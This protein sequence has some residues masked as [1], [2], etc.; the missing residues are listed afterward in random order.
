M[1]ASWRLGQTAAAWPPSR[2]GIFCFAMASEQLPNPEP[3]PIPPL[4]LRGARE[5]RTDDAWEA[6]VREELRRARRRARFSTPRRDE[7]PDPL[8]PPDDA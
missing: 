8:A 1:D 7:L 4:T 5:R 2:A 6:L 3:P